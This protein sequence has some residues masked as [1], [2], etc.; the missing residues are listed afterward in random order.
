MK[1]KNKSSLNSAKYTDSSDEYEYVSNIFDCLNLILAQA[2]SRDSL[3]FHAFDGSK[4]MLWFLK[5][6]NEHSVLAFKALA[7]SVI[8]LEKS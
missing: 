1:H 6:K 2:S 8:G 4:I 5:Q 3:Q 7:R